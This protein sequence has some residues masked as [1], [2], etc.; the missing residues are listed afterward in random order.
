MK[1]PTKILLGCLATPFVLVFALVLLML[2]F[3]LAPI[4]A[5]EQVTTSAEPIGSV[6]P[7]QLAAEGLT[8]DQAR[9]GGRVIPVKIALEEGSFTIKPSPP[10]TGI[11][12]EGD[13]DGSVYALKQEVTRDESG[14]PSYDISFLPKYTML[15]RILSQG[16]IEIDDDTNHL[17]IY[18]ARDLPISLD[19]QVSKGQ[20]RLYLGGLALQ[21]A[22]L[23][24]TMGEHDVIVN[25][26]NPIEMTELQLDVGMGEIDLNDLGNLRAASINVSGR[27][28]EVSLDMGR[29]ISRDTV[30]RT[31]MKMGEMRVGLPRRARVTARTS[32]FLGESTGKARDNRYDDDESLPTLTVDA[33]IT[34]GELRYTRH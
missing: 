24:L 13:F 33:G 30:L 15:R 7:E 2:A 21:S 29:E 25:E 31:R 23:R 16:F 19:A 20:S 9:P 14:L 28:G 4:P 32:V 3:R 5:S 17:T 26:P 8:L 12:V 6:T 11:R 18:I 34:F 1:T 27:M 10:G 22:S